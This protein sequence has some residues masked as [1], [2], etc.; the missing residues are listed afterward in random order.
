VYGK[1]EELKNKAATTARYLL[2][3][4]VLPLMTNS[5]VHA[6]EHGVTSTVDDSNRIKPVIYR[7]NIDKITGRFEKK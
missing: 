7:I 2:Y 1:F 5:T 3:S 6:H 4:R